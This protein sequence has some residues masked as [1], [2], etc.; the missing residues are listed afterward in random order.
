[1]SQATEFSLLAPVLET[2][3]LVLD[4]LG[5]QNP[6]SWVRDEVAYILNHRYNENKVTILTTN[7]KDEEE[8]KDIKAGITDTLSDRIGVRM[9]SRLYEM[10]K[11][12]KMD[13]NDFR[14]AVKQA[15]HHF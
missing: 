1:V 13:G 14:R 5:A 2:E 10:C 6:S 15:E 8:R 3:V 7:Y 9:R 11:T 4:E 12:I